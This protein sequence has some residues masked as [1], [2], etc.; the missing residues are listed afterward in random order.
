MREAEIVIIGTGAWGT[1]LAMIYATQGRRTVLVARDAARADR[2]RTARINPRLPG[3]TLPATLDIAADPPQ[4]AIT[5]LCPPFQ[6]LRETLSRLPPGDGTIVLCCKG[7]ERG[8][9]LLGPEIIARSGI[10]HPVAL[11]TGPNFAH[12]IAACQPAAAVLAMAAAPE[13]HRLIAALATPQFRLYGSADLIGAALGGAAK[14]VIALAAGAV[15]GAGLGENARAA[16]VTR[17]LAEI[18]R[19][20]VALGGSAETIAGLAGL[21]DL[22]LTA[23]GNAS[24]NYRAGLALG[25]GQPAPTPTQATDDSVVEGIETAPALLAR[26]RSVGC[27]MPITEAVTTLLAGQT[28]LATS[29][30]HLMR[31]HLRDEG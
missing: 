14:N 16:L 15:I 10:D 21:G 17:G 24:R 9:A 20:A 2:L 7:V 13:R 23:T 3:F 1:A 11:L 18:A 19:L 6:H 30:E 5:L 22:I 31:R 12:E 8:T 4:A 25:R 28:S 29:I 26:A 27:T